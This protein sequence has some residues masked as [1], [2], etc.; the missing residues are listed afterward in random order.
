VPLF[1]ALSYDAL[2]VALVVMYDGFIFSG[3]DQVTF[4]YLLDITPSERRPQYIA[5][6][7]FFVGMGVFVGALCGGLLATVFENQIFLLFSGIQ[8]VFLVSFII[9]VISL[10]ILP[11]IS[12]IYVKQTELAPVKYVLWQAVAVEPVKGL[13]NAVHFTF[14]Y[15]YE[16]EKE[17]RNEIK[18]IRYKVAIRKN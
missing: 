13:N 11:K 15:P 2:T 16:I 4:N 9:R 3:F 8:I 5:N 14:R 18:K 6:H 1:W 12:E 17:F 10:S 7:N